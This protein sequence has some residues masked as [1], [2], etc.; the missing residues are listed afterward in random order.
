LRPVTAEPASHPYELTLLQERS[1]GTFAR[2]YLAETI[3][4]DGLARIVAVKVLKEEWSGS[5]ELLARTRDEAQ[6]LA[7]LHHRNILRVEALVEFQGRPTIVMEFVDG[8]DLK[9]LIEMLGKQGRRIPSRSVFKIAQDTASALEAAWERVP[10][11]RNEPLAV[12]HRDLKPSNIM[13]SIEGEVKVLDFGTARFQHEA[14]LAKTGVLRFGSM[15]YMSPERRLG[16]RG[17]H[18]SDI[19]SLGVLV[20][21]MLAGRLL[22]LLPLDQAEH[23]AYIGELIASLGHLE[24]PNEQ[25]DASFRQTLG[26]MMAFEPEMRLTAGQLVK[27]LRAFS[28]QAGGSSLDSFAAETVGRLARETY[29]GLDKGD[30]SGSQIFVSGEPEATETLGAD[31]S[32]GGLS[33]HGSQGSHGSNGSPGG[34]LVAERSSRSPAPAHS[35]GPSA[36]PAAVNSA[37]VSDPSDPLFSDGLVDMGDGFGSGPASEPMGEEPSF[38]EPTEWVHSPQEAHQ[39]EAFMEPTEWVQPTVRQANPGHGEFSGGLDV[40]PTQRLDEATQRLDDSMLTESIAEPMPPIARV[41]GGQ[42]TTR[43]LAPVEEEDDPREKQRMMLVVVGTLAGF[44]M[45]I[46]IVVAAAA[47]WWFLKGRHAATTTAVAAAEAPAAS[48]GHTIEVSASDDQIQWIKLKDAAGDKV[49]KGTPSGETNVASGE[50]ELSVKVIGR[51]AVKTMLDISGPLSLECAPEESQQV[52]CAMGE[53]EI[54]LEP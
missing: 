33:S 50:Y 54:L 17:D 51:S 6:L 49:L 18:V 5:E 19:Y 12:V 14:R 24:L 44:L 26:R 10:Y 35:S 48:G 31:G 43:N 7:R 1:S 11:G 39:G 52:L 46:L 38:M 9:Q 25:W 2:V 22:P 8:V 45:L 53:E 13:L 4:V 21:E 3:G 15:K 40:Q 36:R 34:G 32:L 37:L 42:S 16:E 23:D 27:L 28:E 47:G 30:L 29:G 41:G 20:V